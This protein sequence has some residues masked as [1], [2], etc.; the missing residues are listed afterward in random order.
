MARLIH[1]VPRLP[2]ELCGVGDYATLVGGKIEALHGHV[3]CAYI[4]CGHHRSEAVINSDKRR[5]ITGRCEPSELWRAVDELSGN[6]AGDTTIILHYS[7]YGYAP[8]GVP[9][10][11]ADAIERRPG[12]SSVCRIVT[13]FHELYATGQPWERAFWTSS[14]QQAVARRIARASDSLLTNREQSAR[15][16]EAKTGRPTGTVRH[17]AV[18]SNVGEPCQLPDVESRPHAIVFGNNRNS[19]FALGDYGHRVALVLLRLNIRQLIHIGGSGTVDD[20]PFRDLGIEL[21]HVGRLASSQISMHLLQSRIGFIDYPIGFC[22]KSGILAAYTSHGVVPIFR[23]V[24]SVASRHQ[25]LD[26]FVVSF[27]QFEEAIFSLANFRAMSHAA[28]SWYCHHSIKAHST[29]FLN[30]LNSALGTQV[31]RD[32]SNC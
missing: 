14:R 18:C 27:R 16:L 12:E 13:F 11:L 8:S 1:L 28:Y 7:G 19:Q 6:S 31:F 25:G 29:L 4:S 22:E 23:H 9:T 10:W 15:W 32:P 2:P 5:D 17:L 30:A 20:R 21:R 26:P 24:Q 3:S